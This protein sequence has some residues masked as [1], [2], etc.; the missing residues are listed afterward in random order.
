MDHRKWYR[1]ELGLIRGHVIMEETM[2]AVRQRGDGLRWF[3][4]GDN[5]NDDDKMIV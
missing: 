2:E 5:D 1:D 3:D 4:G